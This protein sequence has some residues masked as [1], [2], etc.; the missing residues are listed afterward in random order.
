MWNRLRLRCL[1]SLFVLLAMATCPVLGGDAPGETRLKTDPEAPGLIVEIDGQD[2]LKLFHNEAGQMC[3]DMFNNGGNIFIGTLAG[4]NAKPEAQFNTVIGDNAGIYTAE[5]KLNTFLGFRAGSYSTAGRNT[6]LGALSGTKLGAG[7]GN[8]LAGCSAG[9]HLTAGNN[10]TLIGNGTAGVLGTG[11]DNIMIGAGAGSTARTGNANVFLGGNAGYRNADGSGNVFLGNQAGMQET[12]SNLLYIE[13]TNSK[14]PLVYGEFNNNI[15]GV[16]GKL[17]VGTKAPASDLHIVHGRDPASAGLTIENPS[18][19]KRSWRLFTDAASGD[20]LLSSGGAG[21]AA[22]YTI[23]S[24]AQVV[25]GAAELTD[26]LP[27][28]LELKTAGYQAQPDE[29]KKQFPGLVTQGRY[30]NY[31]GLSVV[32]I[33]AIKE[34]QAQIDALREQNALLMKK[35]EELAARPER[36]G[37]A[38]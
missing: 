10:N 7:E 21:D 31:G 9:A 29:L 6:C 33:Q 8:T 15:V 34:Q 1:V 14:E 32:A 23:A 35:V 13:N 38:N 2:H 4:I 26:V 37:R 25:E 11:S 30:V 16:H 22:G 36:A 17:G 28:A 12:G 18:G 27:K 19:A 5:S 20:L 3:M 24:T